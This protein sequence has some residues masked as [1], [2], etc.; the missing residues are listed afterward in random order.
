MVPYFLVSGDY[1][2][3]NYFLTFSLIKITRRMH[4]K[5]IFISIYCIYLFSF[6][7]RPFDF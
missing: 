6:L 3:I 7:S 1:V 2:M 5:K 4:S